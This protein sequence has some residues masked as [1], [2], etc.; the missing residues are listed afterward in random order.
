MGAAPY[1]QAAGALVHPGAGT[2][3]SAGSASAGPRRRNA[4]MTWLLPLAV[5]FG[6][7][8]LSVIL[9]FIYSPLGSLFA[10]F[11]LV[12]LIWYVILAIQMANELKAVTRNPSF[13]WWPIFVPI[14]SLYWMWLLVPQEVTRAKQMI[15]VQTP[16]RPIVLYI[17]LWH[18]ALA[19]DLNDLAR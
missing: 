10:L 16:T 11:W 1:G 18:F 12:G 6:G 7:V 9:A 14:Y 17:F 8:V 2:L 3:Q 19:S 4:I 13:A 5:I 15:G